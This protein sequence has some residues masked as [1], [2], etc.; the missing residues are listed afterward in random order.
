MTRGIEWLLAHQRESGKWF[1]RSPVRECG[2]R[3]SNAVACPIPRPAPVMNQTLFS[4]MSVPRVPRVG[5]WKRHKP[6]AEPRD[7]GAG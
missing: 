4:A 6:D 2:N 7:A 1:T 5:C 3:I